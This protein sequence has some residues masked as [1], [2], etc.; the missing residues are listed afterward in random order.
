MKIVAS[1]AHHLHAPSWEL[2]RGKFLPAFEKPERAEIV[3]K[4]LAASQQ[5]R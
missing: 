2:E 5:G 1:Q 3:L 4:S